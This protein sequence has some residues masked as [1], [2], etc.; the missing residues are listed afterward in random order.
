MASFL[1]VVL[2]LRGSNRLEARQ[3]RVALPSGED[4]GERRTIRQSANRAP[5]QDKWAAR[6]RR[7]RGIPLTRSLNKKAAYSVAVFLF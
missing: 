4:V 3:I 1:F 7:E 6:K 5:T 2:V